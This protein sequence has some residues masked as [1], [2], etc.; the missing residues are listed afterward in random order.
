MFTIGCCTSYRN[1]FEVSTLLIN[2]CRLEEVS[3]IRYLKI[4]FM[5]TDHLPESAFI[6]TSLVIRGAL[7]WSFDRD[8][9]PQ[10]NR[11]P[12][13][14]VRALST[15]SS[16]RKRCTVE[17]LFSIAKS[18]GYFLRFEFLVGRQHT[19]SLGFAMVVYMVGFFGKIH[20]KSVYSSGFKFGDA[21]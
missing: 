17:S 19:F 4:R 5:E 16:T 13:L 21:L 18:N 12:C 20:R 10:T 7:Q 1:S 3:K 15:N 14:I 8:E 6:A 2:Q 9:Q 11:T